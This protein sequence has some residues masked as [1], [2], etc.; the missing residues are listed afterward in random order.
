MNMSEEQ[1]TAGSADS[2]QPTPRVGRTFRAFPYV[3]LWWSSLAVIQIFI[4]GQAL[5]PPLGQLNFMQALLIMA[6]TAVIFVVVLSLNGE[7]GLE[8]GIPFSV[9]LRPP[10]GLRG[11]K[12]IEFMRALPAVVWFGIG[13]WIAALAMDGILKTLAGFSSPFTAYVY[14][15]A[16]QV[17]QTVLAYRGIRAIKQFSTIASIVIGAVL[18][19]ILIH[20]LSTY[21]LHSSA[22]WNHA[23]DWGAPFWIGLTGAIGVLAPVMLNIS[24]ITRHVEGTRRSLWLG[25]LCGVTPPWF[26]MLLLGMAVGLA[27]GIWDPVQALMHLSPNPVITV[28]FLVFIVTAQVMTNL[29]INILPPAL[30]FME[31]FKTSWARGVLI[32]GVLATLSFPWA[33][34]A[35]SAAFFGFILYYSAF[36]APIVGVMLAD[37]YLIRRGR[38]NVAALYAGETTSSYWYRNGFNVAGLIAVVVPGVITMLVCRH[39]AW[40][41]GLPAGFIVYSVTA[42]KIIGPAA[43]AS[44]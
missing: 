23:S 39:V 38:L 10:F 4:V 17:A 12:I 20:T 28:I 21:G 11:A 25:H 44:A 24:D 29:T 34:M 18:I 31:T 30:V 41:V 3:L 14:F 9:Q 22:S 35:N 33:L 5:L 1:A 19:Y 6:L 2:I 15:A 43:G 27:L 8:Y 16:L 7:A 32:T 36:F 42:R 40:L 26:F 37:Y 13:S